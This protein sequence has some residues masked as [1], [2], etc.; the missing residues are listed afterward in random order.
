MTGLPA[1]IW[2]LGF[3]SLLMDTSSEL[4]HSL[5]PVFMSTVLGA[6]MV[7]IGV[8]EGVAE[9]TAA[10]VKVF[11]G[12]LSDHLRK[13]KILLLVGYGL[14]ALTKPVFPLAN[15]IGWVFAARFVDRIGKGI[16]GAPRDAMVADLVEPA[17]RGAAYG[18]RQAL[19]SVGAFLGPLLALGLM[20]LWA[21]KIQ[22][23]LWAAVVPAVLAVVV[24][25]FGVREPSLTDQANESGACEDSAPTSQAARNRFSRLN[26]SQL[27]RGYWLVVALGACFTLA[28]FSEAF[29][30]L[31]ADN[32]GLAVSF[33][34]LV[35][36]AMNVVYALAAYPAGRLADR[37]PTRRLL[38]LG[39]ALLVVA[40]WW[41]ACAQSTL[42]VFAGAGF[43]G[44]HMAM[45]QGLLAKL[46]ADCAPQHLRGT[47]FGLFN[48]VTGFSLLLASAMAGLLWTAFGP[49]ATF[50]G[51]AVFAAL[52]ALGI[53]FSPR[54]QQ[55]GA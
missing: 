3:V 54:W 45:T 49:A 29:L 18:L 50:A 19:D 17:R 4:V 10:M 30:I 2:A 36:I 6:S 42:W 53:L 34:P 33:A 47:A 8:I 23:V 27:S 16:R 15:A 46:V 21:G 26:L 55:A 20:L 5:L 28:R 40:D 1:S 43:W 13:R 37:V 32:I 12:A 52:A 51:S 9:A 11:S 7:T 25:M 44:L 38:L 48:L 35:M 22:W 39:L 41:L 24:L 31:R 14:A